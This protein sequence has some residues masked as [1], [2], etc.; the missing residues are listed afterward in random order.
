MALG[1]L[2]IISAPSGAGKTSLVKAL[3][4]QDS[5][6]CVSVSFTTRTPRKGEK[7]GVH[8][9]F[10]SQDEF[11]QMLS[12]KAFLEHAQVFDHYYGT[13]QEWVQ[14]RLE[15][16]I[17]V[18]LEIDW[19]GAEQVRQLQ[20]D[21]CNIFILPP[22]YETLVKRLQKRGEPQG[23][24]ERRMA[25]AITEMSHYK[26]YDYLVVNDVFTKALE[27][28]QAIIHSHRLSCQVQSQRLTGLL[29][30]LL[31]K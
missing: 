20:P 18:I 11:M 16:G 31:K 5:N 29:N 2:F 9:N 15:Q 21:I 17:D 3:I 30:D 1:T 4:E 22:T 28:L 25:G 10:V 8:Y 7:S 26:E 24:V 13:S 14:S 19:Q 6:I 12:D 27:D 23:V